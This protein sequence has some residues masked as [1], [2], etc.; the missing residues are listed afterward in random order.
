MLLV[1]VKVVLVGMLAAEDNVDGFI[2]VA[3]SG[4]DIGD[5]IVDQVNNTA[6]NLLKILNVF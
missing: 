5:V 3:G 6:P 4:K 2:S 1:M